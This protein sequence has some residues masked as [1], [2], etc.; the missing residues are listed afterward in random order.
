VSSTQ[1]LGLNLVPQENKETTTFNTQTMLN[2]NWERIDSALG[3][4]IE[5]VDTSTYDSELEIYRVVNYRR[6][7]DNSLYLKM[8]LSNKSNGNYLT[9]TWTEYSNDGVTVKRTITWTLTYDSRG[10]IIKKVPS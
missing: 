7:S 5:E 1:N 9:D 6:P 2:E 3:N 10:K 8:A 4:Y